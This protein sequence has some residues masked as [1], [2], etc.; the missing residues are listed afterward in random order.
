M[1][2]PVPIGGDQS[3][4]PAVPFMEDKVCFTG[5]I[6]VN[7][8][9]SQYPEEVTF[10]TLMPSPSNGRPLDI[11]RLGF[12][13]RPMKNPDD[14]RLLPRAYNPY[15]PNAGYEYTPSQSGF[16]ERLGEE[17]GRLVDDF[18]WDPL[19]TA[20]KFAVGNVATTGELPSFNQ[21]VVDY[22]NSPG[23]REMF[24]ETSDG[25][26]SLLDNSVNWGG[27]RNDV[28]MGIR[29]ADTDNLHFILSVHTTQDLGEWKWDD[30][31]G[32]GHFTN[33]CVIAGTYL[34]SELEWDM[35]ITADGG[36]DFTAMGGVGAFV[37]LEDEGYGRFK[38]YGE[39]SLFGSDGEPLG[40]NS[41]FSM[42]FSFGKRGGSSRRR[43]K[44]QDRLR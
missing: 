4:E 21:L 2:G 20:G 8:F 9:L 43:N 23:A 44:W 38:L 36:V 16:L 24:D 1:A 17:G 34:Y 35:P 3:S 33:T 31:W 29:A 5:E 32:D 27:F 37:G 13:N 39:Q 12:P 18:N 10:T 40:F 19:K 7:S 26:G 15:L 6:T 41:G 28:A 22:A 30:I 42:S 14:F 11:G 25:I